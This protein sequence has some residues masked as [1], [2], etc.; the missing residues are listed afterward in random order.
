VAGIRACVI[1]EVPWAARI[2]EEAAAGPVDGR[3]KLPSEERPR[4]KEEQA[5][6]RWLW[7]SLHG[8]LPLGDGTLGKRLEA[9][10]VATPTA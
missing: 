1:G 9:H 5:H 10:G 7:P 3:R 4:R 6:G 2:L 8:D